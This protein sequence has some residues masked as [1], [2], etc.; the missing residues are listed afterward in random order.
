MFEYVSQELRADKEI[1]LKV[2]EKDPIMFKYASE[3]L[4][5]DKDFILLAIKKNGMVFMFASEYI[6]ADKEIVLKVIEEKTYMFMFASEDIRADK[7]I[8]LKVIENDPTMFEYVAD[9]IM[10]DKEFV[11]QVIDKNPVCINYVSSSLLS[12]EEKIKILKSNSLFMNSLYLLSKDIEEYINNKE[13]DMSK[14]FF[15][16]NENISYGYY[17]EILRKMSPKDIENF[18]VV[19]ADCS[20]SSIEKYKKI[21]EDKKIN[22]IYT[23]GYGCTEQEFEQVLKKINIFK[24]LVEVP[25]D[26]DEQRDYKVFAQL[27]R[28]LANSI[29]YD[30]NAILPENKNNDYMMNECRN[31]YG[32]LVKGKSVC[33][34]YANILKQVL[35]QYNINCE[36]I[37]SKTSEGFSHAYNQV[38]IDGQWYNCDLTS[39]ALEIRINPQCVVYSLKSDKEFGVNEIFYHTPAKKVRN[40]VCTY[41]PENIIDT[42]IDRTEKFEKEGS[43]L[44]NRERLE[45]KKRENSFLQ[46]LLQKLERKNGNRDN[47][48]EER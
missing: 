23:C 4:K 6:R 41:Y 10:L 19:L 46:K 11:L 43:N 40:C 30:Y 20:S 28:I 24:K 18:N 33:A 8:I 17:F 22:K 15:T 27:Y 21:K 14:L 42:I 29:V 7:E 37:I 25:S 34:G 39:D 26:N 9:E 3:E 31:L 13:F 44:D 48:N 45:G 1:V 32:G 36:Y 35:S 38:F 5:A 2:I 16:G 12:D 47:K